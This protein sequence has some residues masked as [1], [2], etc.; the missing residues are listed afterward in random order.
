MMGF[1]IKVQGGTR[2]ILTKLKNINHYILHTFYISEVD[3]GSQFILDF[4]GNN[5]V[6][7]DHPQ[8]A[9]QE[10]AD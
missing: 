6:N 8:Q 4:H 1:S 10:M 5:V 7:F 9:T 2:L 3:I